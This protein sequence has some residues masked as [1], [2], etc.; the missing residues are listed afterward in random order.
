MDSPNGK[1]T[2]CIRLI[3]PV[4]LPMVSLRYVGLAKDN[5]KSFKPPTEERESI[6]STTAITELGTDPALE[7]ENKGGTGTIDHER[8]PC[9]WHI[10]EHLM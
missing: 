9:A 3:L 2:S 5:S 6:T 7:H 8:E 10:T 4:V 1:I